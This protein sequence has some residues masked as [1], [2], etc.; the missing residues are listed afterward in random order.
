MK[1]GWVRKKKHRPAQLNLAFNQG[2]DGRCQGGF[3]GSQQ[4]EWKASGA[5]AGHSPI[6]FWQ[7][8]LAGFSKKKTNVREK[9]HCLLADCPDQ[10]KRLRSRRKLPWHHET[11]HPPH[12]HPHHVTFFFRFLPDFFR[13]FSSGTSTGSQ[14]PSSCT[15]WP[16]PGRYVPYKWQLSNLKSNKAL[17]RNLCDSYTRINV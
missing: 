5:R 6:K 2:S 10:A 15:V 16:S 3:V 1:V 9:L 8:L 17:G 13:H 14:Q 12:P 4:D 7:K 11:H